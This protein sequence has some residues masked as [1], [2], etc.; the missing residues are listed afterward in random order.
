MV[1][2]E[3]QKNK[4]FTKK[5][6]KEVYT[7]KNPLLIISFDRLIPETSLKYSQSLGL[8]SEEYWRFLGY[9]SEYLHSAHLLWRKNLDTTLREYNEK[10]Q[11]NHE[12]VVRFDGV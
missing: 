6:S 1:K 3:T 11:T 5:Q 4:T 10:H 12:W 2:K 9:V 8:S 7:G